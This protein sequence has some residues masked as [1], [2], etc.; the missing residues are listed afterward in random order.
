MI[1]SHPLPFKVR[2]VHDCTVTYDDLFV[3]DLWV[4]PRRTRLL[5]ILLNNSNVAF[6]TITNVGSN[7]RDKLTLV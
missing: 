2:D 7:I 5:K 3:L 6:V 1:M 4:K